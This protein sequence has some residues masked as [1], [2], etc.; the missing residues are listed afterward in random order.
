[1]YNLDGKVA[2]VTGAG[3]R[4]GIGRAIAIRLAQEGA[5]VVANDLNLL[6]AREIGEYEGWQGLK[7][8]AEEIDALGRKS[9]AITANISNEKEVDEMV[10]KALATF[11]KIDILVNNAGVTGTRGI[12]LVELEEKDW[13]G[14]LAVMLNGTFH[15]CRAVGKQMVDKG[16]KGRIINI[17][18]V[19]GKVAFAGEGAYDPAKFGILGLNQSL[20]I[21]LAPYGINVNAVCPGIV[22]TDLALEAQ[23][24]KAKKENITVEESRRHYYEP[25]DHLA[26][27]GRTGEPEDIASMVAFLASSEADF[28]VGQA[29]NVCG[30]LLMAH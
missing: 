28:I 10:S 4:R 23:K 16:I 26:P 25:L 12:P 27:L 21:E 1:M 7:S 9:L 15:C 3:G 22:H 20:A 17:A 30:G 6:P 29:I 24:I 14:P 5:D 19:N 11:G 18:S 13:I 2:L 8:V